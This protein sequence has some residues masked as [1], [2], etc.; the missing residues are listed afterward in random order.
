VRTVRKRSSRDSSA[1]TGSPS[2]VV[3][4]PLHY[5]IPFLCRDRGSAAAAEAV[6]SVLRLGWPLGVVGGLLG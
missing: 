5:K 6:D 3:Y 4:V 1:T 2:A